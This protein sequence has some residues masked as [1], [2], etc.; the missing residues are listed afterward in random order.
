VAYLESLGFDC[1]SNI[2]DH[3][4]YDRLKEVEHKIPVFNWKSLEIVKQLKA[5]GVDTVRQRCLQASKH[6]QQILKT[7]KQQWPDNFSNWLNTLSSQLAK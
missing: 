2:I 4:H 5:L 7:M 1:M 3:N 6:N